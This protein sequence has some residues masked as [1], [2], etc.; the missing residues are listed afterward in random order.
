MIVSDGL[1]Y[2]AG[3]KFSS[4]SSLANYFIACIDNSGSV[5][6]NR[7]YGND[8]GRQAYYKIFK[9]SNGNFLL[10]GSTNALIGT[11][12]NRISIIELNPQGV[13][14]NAFYFE[15][16]TDQIFGDAHFDGDGLFILYSRIEGGFSKSY[17]C[18]FNGSII[19]EYDNGI[20]GLATSLELIDETTLVLSC[21]DEGSVAFYKITYTSNG[22]DGVHELKTYPGSIKSTLTDRKSVV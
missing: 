10:V 14:V 17:L 3:E 16:S 9:K 7:E 22:V 5:I 18:Y 15:S 19:W 21:E 13:S 6:W 20:N 8:Q 4:N 11:T 2:V 1:V 12:L